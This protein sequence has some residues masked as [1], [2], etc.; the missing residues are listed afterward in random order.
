MKKSNLLLLILSVV[1]ISGLLAT[2]HLLA[3]S[4]S[5]IDLKDPYKNFSDVAVK[6]FKVL[7]I[8]GGN[9]YAVRIEQG[10]AF[11]IKVMNTRASFFKMVPAG[12]TLVI[13]F[14]VANQRY[15]K[16]E[17]C[18]VGLIIAVPS[19]SFLN[20][21]GINA[22]INTLQQ[23]SLSINQNGQTTTRMKNITVNRLALSGSNVS[24][25][26]CVLNNQANELSLTISDSASI[27][28]KQMRFQKLNTIIKDKAAV[29]FYQQSFDMLKQVFAAINSLR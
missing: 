18:T 19:L 2:D 1:L 23:D 27:Q 17:D 28:M 24:S 9:S 7:N 22:E 14:N 25:Y 26:D 21:S 15:Q 12:D 5:K 13:N 11:N 16:P 8:N 29:V 10:S 6:P 4:Y 20:L 3:I